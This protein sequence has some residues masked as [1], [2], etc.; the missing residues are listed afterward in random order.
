MFDYFVAPLRCPHCGSVSPATAVTGMQTHI[1]RDA[2]GS[3]LSVGY[4]F[5]PGDL[6]T[7]HILGAGYALIAAPRSEG[8]LRLLD[9]WTCPECETEEWAVVDIV[10]R[11]IERI[12]AVRLDRA[13]L[14]SS[15]YISDVNSDLLA[16]ALSDL[17]QEEMRD[18]NVS[19][20][21]I[22]RQQLEQ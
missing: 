6:K 18:R 10:N 7:E 16:S 20:I 11:R 9:V 17:S 5:D 13:T 12:E 22:L 21:E 19:S 3:E 1:R 14:E 15:N 8:S 2:N 4:V